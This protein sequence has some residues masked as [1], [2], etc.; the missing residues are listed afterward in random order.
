MATETFSIAQGD[1][2]PLLEYIPQDGNGTAVAVQVGDTVVFN[3]KNVRTGVVKINRGAAEVIAGSP[4]YFRYTW[5]TG[6][7]DTAGTYQAEWEWLNATKPTTFPNNDA[8]GF[9]V[10]IKDDIA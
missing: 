2:L 9:L 10:K 8:S 5:V 6:D 7:T 1:L 3:M 4:S